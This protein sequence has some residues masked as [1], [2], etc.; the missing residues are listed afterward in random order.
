M[1]NAQDL[2]VWEKELFEYVYKK[3]QIGNRKKSTYI[4]YRDICLKEL[5]EYVFDKWWIFQIGNRIKSTV[6][7]LGGTCIELVQD[8]GKLQGNPTD[9]FARKDMSDHARQVNEKVGFYYFTYCLNLIT[10]NIEHCD[11]VI[12]VTQKLKLLSFS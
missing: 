1:F 8:C 3:F 2:H 4:I 12:I 5:F 6:A 11:V 9:N 10:Q 7:D